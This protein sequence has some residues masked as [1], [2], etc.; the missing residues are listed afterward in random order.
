MGFPCSSDG[1]ESTCNV[2]DLGLIPGLG[3]S[4]GG[5]KSSQNVLSHQ[6]IYVLISGTCE[7]VI[8]HEKGNFSD[9]IE[10]KGLEM[11]RLFW[12]S[13][14]TQANDRNL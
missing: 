1:K 5:G 3:S 4:P 14:W 9:V 12:I 2:G 11:G 13:W 6:A 10:V 8:L 7:Y